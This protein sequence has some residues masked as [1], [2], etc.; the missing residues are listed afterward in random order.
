MEC[1]ISVLSNMEATSHTELLNILSVASTT[2]L[3]IYLFINF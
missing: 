2:E 1:S 3:F